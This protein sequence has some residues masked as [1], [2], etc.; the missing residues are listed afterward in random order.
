MNPNVTFSASSKFATGGGT[1]YSVG[2]IARYP[3]QIAN[4]FAHTDFSFGSTENDWRFKATKY[5]VIDIFFGAALPNPN[6]LVHIVET[7]DPTGQCLYFN[8]VLVS[9]ANDTSG[10][11]NT[12]A[13]SFNSNFTGTLAFAY[14]YPKKTLTAEQVRSLN[15]SPYQF[16][17]RPSYRLISSAAA[18]TGRLRRTW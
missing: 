2:V 9:T 4:L 8:G 11:R 3:V 10:I 12:T 17:Q 16:I 1:R 7:Y 18:A 6:K 5:G 15:A 13:P 14:A